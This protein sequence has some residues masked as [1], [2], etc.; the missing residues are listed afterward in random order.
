MKDRLFEI[1]HEI[2]TKLWDTSRR[3]KWRKTIL[4]TIDVI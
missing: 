1:G 2:K 3:N 4:A